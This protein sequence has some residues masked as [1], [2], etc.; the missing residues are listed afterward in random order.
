MIDFD[1]QYKS[2]FRLW[3]ICVINF[4]TV[5]LGSSPAKFLKKFDTS[6]KKS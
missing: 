5:K 4:L 3:S 1:F 2:T 6:E